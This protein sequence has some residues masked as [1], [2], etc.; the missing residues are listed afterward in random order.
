MCHTEHVFRQESL[1]RGAHNLNETQHIHTG[2]K[3][4]EWASSRDTDGQRSHGPGHTVCSSIVL[5][6]GLC[7]GERRAE[8]GPG[9]PSRK[10]WS[11]GGLSGERQHQR[12]VVPGTGRGAD[13]S[14]VM[15]EEKPNEVKAGE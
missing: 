14:V 7:G 12:A 5:L 11:P 13:L 1:P 8:H 15:D 2:H 4:R 6:G 9:W 3:H 10:Q